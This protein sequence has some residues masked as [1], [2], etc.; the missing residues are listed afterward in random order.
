M[1]EP[2]DPTGRETPNDPLPPKE[3]ALSAPVAPPGTRVQ[4]RCSVCSSHHVGTPEVILIGGNA[5]GYCPVCNV[6]GIWTLK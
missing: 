1:S 5:K 4:Y 2:N 6:L 3:P